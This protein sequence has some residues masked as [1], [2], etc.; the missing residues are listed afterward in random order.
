VEKLSIIIPTLNE[1]ENLNRILNTLKP[2]MS[3][4]DEIIVVDGYSKDGTPEIAKEYGVKLIF[5]EPR[6]IGAAK[7]EGAKNA[8]NDILI[9]LDADSVP[10]DN[11]LSRIKSHFKNENLNALFG[12]YLYESDFPIR[13]FIYNTFS[14]GCFFFG[15]IV[16]K[17]TGKYGIPA[18]N[19]AFKKDIFFSVGGYRSVIC[20]DFDL[21]LRLP[22][23]RNV[24]FDSNLVVLLSDRRFREKGFLRVWMTWIWSG[25]LVLIGRAKDGRGY[26]KIK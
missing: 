14:K 19:T 7:T 20:E 11:F 2:Q 25:I 10:S 18:N 17:I 1:K 4:D 6:G 21:M 3:K 16:H 26:R 12:L 5:Q 22:P 9:F 24:K 15:A 13:K 23:S 8:K